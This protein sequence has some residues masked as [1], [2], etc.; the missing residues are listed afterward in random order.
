MTITAN[1]IAERCGV[2]ETSV[3]R[4]GLRWY[5]YI[6]SGARR[7]YT[8]VDAKVARAWAEIECSSEPHQPAPNGYLLCALAEEAIRH[9][10]NC[11]LALSADGAST[12]DT[13]ADA[14][15]EWQERG[16]LFVRLIDLESVVG[17]RPLTGVAS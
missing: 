12:H 1:E 8:E 4:W 9:R 6:G 11:W 3:I 14:V 2:S 10:P 16:D 17:H 15:R 5:G 7:S 13:A